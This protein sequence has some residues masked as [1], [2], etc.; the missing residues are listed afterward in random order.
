MLDR[1]RG[2]ET[3]GR[4]RLTRRTKVWRSLA[5]VWRSLAELSGHHSHNLFIAFET[6][7]NGISTLSLFCVKKHRTRR[8]G[9]LAGLARSALRR[10][11]KVR[12]KSTEMFFAMTKALRPLPAA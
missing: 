4:C 6:R 12:H 10:Q 1:L 9:P 3:V 11:A 7:V 2:R 8:P 5:E